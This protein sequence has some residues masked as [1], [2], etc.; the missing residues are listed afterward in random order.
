MRTDAS[1]GDNVL[2]TEGDLLL[3]LLQTAFPK[4][5]EQHLRNLLATLGVTD[6]ADLTPAQF[7]EFR[8]KI[9]W[10]VKQTGIKDPAGWIS[11]RAQLKLKEVAP[12]LKPL[13]PVADTVAQP[14]SA[15]CEPV[16]LE[17][18]RSIAPVLSAPQPTPRTTLYGTTKAEVLSRIKAAVEARAPVRYIHEMLA[19][20]H[21]DFHAS[22]RELGAAI[23]LSASTINRQLKWHQSGYRE[24]SPYGPTTRAG[25]AAHRNRK[26]DDVD[27]AVEQAQDDDTVS[28][29]EYSAS[30]SQPASQIALNE[31]VP[32][33]SPQTEVVPDGDAAETEVNGVGEKARPAQADYRQTQKHNR[34]GGNADTRRTLSP[35]CM[36]TVIEALRERPIRASAAA[37]AGIHRKTLENWLKCST[38]GQHGFDIEWEGHQW[39]F[40]EACEAAIDEAHDRLRD[41]MLDLAVGPITYKIDQDLVD[42]GMEGY[43]AYA[44][45]EHGDFIE[46]ARGPGNEKIIERVLETLRPQRWGRPR[47]R[48][49]LRNGGVLVIGEAARR[50]AKGSIASTKARQWKVTSRM[51]A[52]ATKG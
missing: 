19:C 6:R 32:N 21:D 11:H 4:N 24:R 30:P 25:R 7:A 48:R 3:E 5:W 29:V 36:R 51:V 47:R 41:L 20:A 9:F 43:D 46:V 8:D 38:A 22:Q 52:A 18:G 14:K 37:K 27:G 17:N 2:G 1:V 45:D 49:S 26:N 44:R 15:D 23:G 12:K 10:M 16:A 40:H 35:K 34:V 39:R 50:S 42:L 31:N 33:V 28:L 13:A